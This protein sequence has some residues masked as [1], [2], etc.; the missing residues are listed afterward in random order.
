[1]EAGGA[2]DGELLLGSTAGGSSVVLRPVPVRR[3][4]ATPAPASEGSSTP[5]MQSRAN[6]DVLLVSTPSPDPGR[7][8]CFRR[9]A[10]SAGASRLGLL[11][12]LTGSLDLDH[13]M[14]TGTLPS[15][16]GRLSALTSGLY[17]DVNSLHGR[18]LPAA[19]PAPLLSFRPAATH[20]CK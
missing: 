15:E 18:H 9:A 5:P 1:M 3:G 6:S 20:G 17:L 4:G 19:P 14:L 11:T 10:T 7:Y 2:A 12:Q 13:N 16:L 8:L